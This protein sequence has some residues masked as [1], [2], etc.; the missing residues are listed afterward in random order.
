MLTTTSRRLLTAALCLAAALTTALGGARTASADAGGAVT[1]DGEPRPQECTVVVI[2]VTGNGGTG[3]DGRMRCWL[4]GEE[5]ACYDP[6]FG[7]LHRDGCRY[8]RA[9]VQDPPPQA[10]PRPGAWYVR[11]CAIGGG[12]GNSRVWFADRDAPG[13]G[14]LIATALA[15][16]R[17][18][19]PTVRTNPGP[20]A[21][22]I[23]H[24]PT[25]LWVDAVTWRPV[26]ATASA[27]GASIT[28]TA[29]PVSVEWLPGDGSRLLC[30]GPGLAWAGG[31][32][33][34]SSACSHAYTRAS[35]AL[36]GGAFALQ[37]V[38]TWEVTWAGAGMSG[39]AGTITT[40]ATVP[41]VVAE[42]QG[43]N[44]GGSR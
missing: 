12:M 30:T 17:P 32:P 40:T 15:A 38:V 18:P 7:W 6:D 16:L 2:V 21:V 26:P 11:S 10:G 42:V 5:V 28:A 34:G 22:P 23:V 37:A 31:D 19:V 3:A 43:L 36:P 33:L 35:A 13:T 1:C 14:P 20:P 9:A 29:T 8:R 25:W 4:N 41:L 44:V 27:G 24:V 39:N